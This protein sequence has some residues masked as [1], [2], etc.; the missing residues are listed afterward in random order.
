MEDDDL[1]N[2]SRKMISTREATTAHGDNRLDEE[3]C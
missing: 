3:L 1:L 2:R